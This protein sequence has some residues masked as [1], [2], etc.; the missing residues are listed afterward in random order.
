MKVYKYGLSTTL[1]AIEDALADALNT[2]NKNEKIKYISEAY[3]MIRAINL[4]YIDD[5]D[6][7]SNDNE[8]ENDT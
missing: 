4:F 1:E 3:G 2:N 5:D 8:S 6:E 7:N